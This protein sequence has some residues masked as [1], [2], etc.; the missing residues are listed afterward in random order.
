V[1]PKFYFSGV[2]AG[3]TLNLGFQLAY[4]GS[5][6]PTFTSITLTVVIKY[7]CFLNIC[8]STQFSE[9]ASLISTDRFLKVNLVC[10]GGLKFYLTLLIFAYI[11]KITALIWIKLYSE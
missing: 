4:A 7:I 8:I 2:S 10:Q 6:A 11:L 9:L 1:T 5:T 3:G